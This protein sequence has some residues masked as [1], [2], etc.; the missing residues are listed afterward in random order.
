MKHPYLWTLIPA[1]VTALISVFASDIRS[2]LSKAARKGGDRYHHRSLLVLENRLG[3]IN[4]IH[5]N[6]YNFLLWLFTE[7]RWSVF[8]TI[9]CAYSWLL[10]P[11]SRDGIN[12]RMAVAA[13]MGLWIGTAVRISRIVELLEH[14]ARSKAYLENRIVELKSKDFFGAQSGAQ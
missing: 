14:Y 10:Y 3:L 8:L 4:W 5:G 11:S 7:L 13:T 9:G 6:A 2:A 1:V 12:L